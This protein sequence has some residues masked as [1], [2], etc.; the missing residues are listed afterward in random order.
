M[1]AI[2]IALMI[3]GVLFALF[4]YF[5]FFKGKYSLINN[6]DEDKKNQKYD[7][8]YAKR[9]GLIEFVGGLI[10]F[11]LGVSTLFISN[12]LTFIVFG[13]SILGVIISLVIN[14]GLSIKRWGKKC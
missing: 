6:F 10:T 8:A 1:F 13:I 4:G 7:D 11:T 2:K 5:I 14:L 3:V 9:M 12:T